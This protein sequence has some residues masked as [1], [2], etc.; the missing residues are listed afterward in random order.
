MYIIEYLRQR[1]FDWTVYCLFI[2]Y[3]VGKNIFSANL[4][5]SEFM[6]VAGMY[7]VLIT[8]ATGDIKALVEIR[9]W[10]GK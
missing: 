4:N 10:F 7:K 2:L 5:Y 1:I 3:H 6:S 8:S 9:G